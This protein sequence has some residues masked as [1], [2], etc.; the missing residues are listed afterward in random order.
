MLNSFVQGLKI[1]IKD[2]RATLFTD[3]D[4]TR[5]SSV[6]VSIINYNHDEYNHQT[7]SQNKKS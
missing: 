2:I 6:K 1:V 4:G 7:Y 3:F 5:R